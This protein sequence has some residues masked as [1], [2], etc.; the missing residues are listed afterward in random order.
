VA[1]KTN[2]DAH[3]AA[4]ANSAAPTAAPAAAAAIARPGKP[5]TAT[6]N[7]C[8]CRTA[9]AD[10]AVP[11]AA[12]AAAAGGV[13]HP[14]PVAA[15]GSVY[16]RPIARTRSAAPTVAPRAGRVALIVRPGR[17]APTASAGA[18]RP[19]HAC[20]GRVEAAFIPVTSDPIARRARR[21][22]APKVACPT[23]RGDHASSQLH[24]KPAT[25]AL[26]ERHVLLRPPAMARAV[27]GMS[28][29]C[30]MRSMRN[31]RSEDF[32]RSVERKRI[33][34]PSKVT[35]WMRIVRVVTTPSA[36][37]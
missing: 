22:E 15:T 19:M 16:A 33:T 20:W 10:N 7:A 27:C 23:A 31:S 4:G 29:A 35:A 14:R 5:V 17:L 37:R 12:P 26:A 30:S 36:D 32:S 1:W 18:R 21:S 24:A 3:R 11:T 34:R 6:A 13:N 8:A 2:A 25:T 28:V 9:G